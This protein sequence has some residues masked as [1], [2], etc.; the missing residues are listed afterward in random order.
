MELSLGLPCA[1]AWATPTNIASV[2]RDAEQYGFR[3]VWTFQRW[4][5][6]PDMANVYQSVLDPVTTLAFAAA[7]T[8]RVRLGVAVI[9]GP[10]YAPAAVAKQLAALDVLSAGRLDAGME[11]WRGLNLELWARTFLD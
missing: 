4:L 2:A 6:T 1:G 10:F 3:G 9:N 7:C 11:L 8:S 5:A